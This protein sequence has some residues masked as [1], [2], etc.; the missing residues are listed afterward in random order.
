MDDELNDPV[1]PEDHS[2]PASP[3]VAVSI[4]TETDVISM[5]TTNSEERSS[6][7][8]SHQ[9]SPAAVSDATMT[10]PATSVGATDSL[11]IEAPVAAASI[12]TAAT[13]TAASAEAEKKQVMQQLA[14][15][16]KLIL[17][18]RQ[19]LENYQ[20]QVSF[21]FRCFVLLVLLTSP[22]L[23]YFIFACHHNFCFLISIPLNPIL[24]SPFSTNKPPPIFMY[25]DSPFQVG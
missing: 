15:Y 13:A 19:V 20:R 9:D 1:A 22:H 4:E 7:E 8:L 6:N 25:C 24:S 10:A 3:E 2:L 14:H 16:K 17:Q 21:R 12:P 5:K 11:D 23:H 18:S